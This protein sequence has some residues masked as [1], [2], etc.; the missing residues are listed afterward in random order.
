[1]FITVHEWGRGGGS[2][3]G[4]EGSVYKNSSVCCL[5]IAHGSV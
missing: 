2:V 4:W 3:V 5:A 1:M